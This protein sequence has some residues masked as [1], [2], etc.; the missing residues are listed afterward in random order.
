MAARGPQVTLE[1]AVSVQWCK[2]QPE[3]SIQAVREQREKRKTLF[4]VIDP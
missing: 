3:G 2:Q 4:F 1:T